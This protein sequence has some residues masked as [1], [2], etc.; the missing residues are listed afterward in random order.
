MAEILD[1]GIEAHVSLVT[2][3]IVQAV[4]ELQS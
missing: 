4:F 3:G 2:S 1:D